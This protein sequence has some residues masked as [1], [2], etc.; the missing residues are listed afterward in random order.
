[1]FELAEE[2]GRAA[3]FASAVF[4]AFFRDDLDIGDPATLIRLAGPFGLSPSAVHAALASESRK[5]RHL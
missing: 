5:R 4:A 3:E 2:I 1:V